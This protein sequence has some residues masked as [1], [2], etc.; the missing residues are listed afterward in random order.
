MVT[1]GKKKKTAGQFTFRFIK[2]DVASQNTEMYNKIR[3]IE[4]NGENLFKL[5]KTQ[6]MH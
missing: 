5:Q 2:K 3:T 6:Q 1:V 4:N